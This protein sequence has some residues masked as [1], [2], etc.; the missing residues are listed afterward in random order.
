MS[1]VTNVP[2]SSWWRI[3]S[4]VRVRIVA[5]EAERSA[6]DRIVFRTSD[7]SA[8]TWMPLPDTS[9]ITSATW[10]RLTGNTS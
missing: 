5:G 2:I 4:F 10:S 7:V 1:A 8:A 3:T 6:S 9:P